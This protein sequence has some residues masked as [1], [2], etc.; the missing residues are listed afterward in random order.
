MKFFPF[1]ELNSKLNG[2]IDKQTK[3]S[4]PIFSD[5][6]DMKISFNES[7]RAPKSRVVEN[8]NKIKQIFLLIFESPQES[9]AAPRPTLAIVKITIKLQNS[10]F[11]LRL[12]NLQLILP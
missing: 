12:K 8:E 1:W 10:T 7:E 6:L 11:R 3:N 4:V 9:L 5:Q 2:L